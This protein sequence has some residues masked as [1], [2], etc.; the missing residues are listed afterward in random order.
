VLRDLDRRQSSDVPD[1]NG[2]DLPGL[3]AFVAQPGKEVVFLPVGMLEAFVQQAHAIEDRPRHHPEAAVKPARLNRLAE[4]L[5][6][7]DHERTGD[8]V[9]QAEVVDVALRETAV[10]VDDRDV[11][12]RRQA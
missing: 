10:V 8:A 2:S 12:A 6:L 5:S 9:R 3:N 7:A 4:P 11:V 1:A